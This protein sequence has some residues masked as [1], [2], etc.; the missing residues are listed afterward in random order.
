MMPI[1]CLA[2]VIAP[3]AYHGLPW[4]A[5]LAKRPGQ[6]NGHD[7]TW[8]SLTDEGCEAFDA[9]VAALRAIAGLG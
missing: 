8:V 6:R 3:V 7:V 1:L 4:W 2:V 5:A 9:H